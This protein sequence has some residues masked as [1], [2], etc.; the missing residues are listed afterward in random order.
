MTFA[1]PQVRTGIHM[2]YTT[3]VLISKVKSLTNKNRHKCQPDV[4]YS[5]TK[6]SQVC[7]QRSVAY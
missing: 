7:F 2:T 4:E 6:F 3:L 1:V 5:L